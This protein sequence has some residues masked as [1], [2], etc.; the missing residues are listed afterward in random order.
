M[1]AISPVRFWLAAL[2]VLAVG[3]KPAEE[4]N[5]YAGIIRPAPAQA[6]P[7]PDSSSLLGLHTYIFAKTCATPGCHDGHFEPDFRTVESTYNTLVFHPVVKN[8][9]R[10]SFKY[11]VIPYDTAQ[12]WL[13]ERVLTDDQVLGRMPLYSPMLSKGEL[14]DLKRWILAG[15]PNASGTVNTKPNLQPRFYTVAAFATSPFAIRIDTFR[16]EYTRPL[17]MLQGMTVELWLAVEDD[18]TDL[19]QLQNM[20]LR[21]STNADNFTTG[22]N[23]PVTYSATP[24]VVPN[25]WGPGNDGWFWLKATVTASAFQLNTPYYYRFY[26]NDGDHSQDAEIPNVNAPFYLKQHHAIFVT[27]Q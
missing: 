13:H 4:A 2:L 21:F 20:R 1:L 25:F 24:K 17:G 11:R 14:N 8:N 23:V 10:N 12:S 22:I 26:V 27:R 19:G 7:P 9:S 15:A 5:P 16:R 3:C 18:S 6:T